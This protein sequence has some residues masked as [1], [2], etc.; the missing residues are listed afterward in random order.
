MAVPVQRSSL[1]APA[2]RQRV[3]AADDPRLLGDVDGQLQEPRRC[4]HEHQVIP[5][6]HRADVPGDAVRAPFL[7]LGLAGRLLLRCPSSGQPLCRR[8]AAP[9]EQQRVRRRRRRALVRLLAP[10]L[11]VVFSVVVVSGVLLRRLLA[12]VQHHEPLGEHARR[13][14]LAFAVV[15]LLRVILVFRGRVRR[16]VEGP[17]PE[18][19]RLVPEAA[20]DAAE[21][22]QRV[23][24]DADGLKPAHL[25]PPPVHPLDLLHHRDPALALVALLLPRRR[26]RCLLGPAHLDLPGAR[27]LGRLRLVVLLLLL[28]R[29]PLR[30]VGPAEHGAG[31]WA[32]RL[33]TPAIHGGAGRAA[34][35]FGHQRQALPRGEADQ[36]VRRRGHSLASSSAS[37]RNRR[38]LPHG[39]VSAKAS[40]GGMQCT[41]AGAVGG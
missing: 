40:S 32:G 33:S 16:I 41:R 37:H 23:P 27:D 38:R 3:P 20:H 5:A 31:P 17:E 30:L 28:V 36:Q 15:L 24:P 13:R 19:A 14:T 10:P 29:S 26:C 9:H 1:P 7:F 22:R 12:A 39:Y 25:L 18:A 21:E 2:P 35:G 4:A 11:F 34:D 6:L 8:R